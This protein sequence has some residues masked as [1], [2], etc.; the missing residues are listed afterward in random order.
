MICCPIA[1]VSSYW[2]IASRF[3][4]IAALSLMGE[5]EGLFVCFSSC[6]SSVLFLSWLFRLSTWLFVQLFFVSFI[7]LF[8][9]SV[10]LFSLVGWLVVSWSPFSLFLVHSVG[11]SC[12]VS[13]F[14]FFLC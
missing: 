10:Y 6:R 8:F 12:V 4:V 9:V 1:L 5:V 13:L 7:L 11:N 2:L 14:L 3:K